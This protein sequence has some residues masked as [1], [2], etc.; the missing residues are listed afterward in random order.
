VYAAVLLFFLPSSA[1]AEAPAFGEAE[2]IALIC[3]TFTLSGNT[4]GDSDG[5]LLPPFEVSEL[6]MFAHFMIRCYQKFVSSQQYNVCLFNPSCSHFGSEAVRRY[7]FMRGVLMTSD[8]LQ[9]CNNFAAQ[10]GY[11]FDASS[12]K[13]KDPVPDLRSESVLSATRVKRVP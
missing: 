2:E 13:L 10:Y 4:S 12:G 9:R 3:S 1:T 6:R 5:A 8:R 7:G 11:E